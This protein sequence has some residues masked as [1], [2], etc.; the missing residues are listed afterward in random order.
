MR[1][2]LLLGP[3]LLGPLLVAALLTACGGDSD[4]TDGATP[5]VAGGLSGVGTGTPTP[6]AGS[7][8]R[9]SPISAG[10]AF[11]VSA[12]GQEYSPSVED[13]KALP[14]TEITVGGKQYSGVE[15]GHARQKVKAVP[16]AQVTVQGYRPDWKR[17]AF[18]RLPAEEIAAETVV[19]FDSEGYISVASTKVPESE[20]LK[21]VISVGFP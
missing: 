1:R 5:T 3:L 12:V 17:V 11:D 16:G 19:F 18:F 7:V 15:P 20:W 13:L 2:S 8:A 21:S 4:K 10:K 14:Q 9:P 6:E